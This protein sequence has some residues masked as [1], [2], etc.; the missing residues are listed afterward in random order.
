MSTSERGPG[1]P[2]RGMANSSSSSFS[3]SSGNSNRR[4]TSYVVAMFLLSM[5]GLGLYTSTLLFPDVSSYYQYFDA[6]AMAFGGASTSSGDAPSGTL[7]HL[8]ISMDER[9]VRILNQTSSATTTSDHVGNSMQEWKHFQHMQIRDGKTLLLT[10][11][12]GDTINTTVV[13]HIASFHQHFDMTRNVPRIQD[14]VLE[15]PSRAERTFPIPPP[16]TASTDES[17]QTT[18]KQE[19]TTNDDTKKKKNERLNIILFY[20]DD[21]TMKVLGKLNPM[22]QTPNIDEMAD[23]GVLFSHN[24]V[25]TSIC[26]ISRATLAT[27]V[28]AAVHQHKRIGGTTMF[29]ETIQWPQTLYPLLKA[30]GYYTGLVGKWHAPAPNPFMRYTFDVFNVYYGE[31]WFK[32]DGKDR[33][34]TDLNGEDALAFLRTRPKDKNFALTVSFF[35]THAMDYHDPPYVP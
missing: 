14:F 23:K 22:V 1:S 32:R 2:P 30:N 13:E 19:T 29:N 7:H 12:G 31:H 24:C 16:M 18:S 21:W 26:W 28:Y 27:G 35:A 5:L 3:S 20:A 25:T 9:I 34:V 8:D 4:A 10:P 15:K 11:F 17:D 33:H 6:S